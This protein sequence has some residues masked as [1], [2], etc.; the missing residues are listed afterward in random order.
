MSPSL[1]R[2]GQLTVGRV[3]GIDSPVLIHTPH[4]PHHLDPGQVRVP[5]SIRIRSAVLLALG[6]LGTAVLLGAILSI[7]VVGAVLLLA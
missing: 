7:V 3:A 2:S 1:F 4:Q 5:T 6:T